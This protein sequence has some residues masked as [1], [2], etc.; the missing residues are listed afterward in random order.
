MVV[1]LL[2][3]WLTFWNARQNCS[4]T[5][6]NDV[7]LEF[8]WT[9]KRY[10]TEPVTPIPTPPVKNKWFSASKIFAAT[11]LITTTSELDVSAWS[12]QPNVKELFPVVLPQ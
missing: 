1:M 11:P 12:L 8:V 5:F 10:L 3:V 6:A 7:S 9:S 2:F 4:W